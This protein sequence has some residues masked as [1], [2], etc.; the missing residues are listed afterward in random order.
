V[1][2]S[3][4]VYYTRFDFTHDLAQGSG[5]KAHPHARI[6]NPCPWIP[7]MQ[8]RL[9]ACGTPLS[10]ACRMDS[11]TG[12]SRYESGPG[13]DDREVIDNFSRLWRSSP[14]TLASLGLQNLLGNE[15]VYKKET[16]GR[17]WWL[18]YVYA[19][20]FVNCQREGASGMG[21]CT[22][23]FPRKDWRIEGICNE[24]TENGPSDSVVVSTEETEGFTEDR[25]HELKSDGNLLSWDNLNLSSSSSVPR[26]PGGWFVFF[27]RIYVRRFVQFSGD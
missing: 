19:S 8:S 24:A 18:A 10:S 3:R 6:Y 11:V 26:F 4:V 14:I 1:P 9:S 2:S 5:S 23:T 13:R 15:N 17:V 7:G 21:P 27:R 25:G 22:V 20:S 12:S 16:W